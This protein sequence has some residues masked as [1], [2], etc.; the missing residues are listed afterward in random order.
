MAD[1]IRTDEIPPENGV[2]YTE[3]EE[4]S[5]DPEIA[6][7]IGGV[8]GAITGLVAGASAGPVGAAIGAVVGG[9]AGSLASQA[10]VAAI[11]N[12]TD[13]HTH[14]FDAVDG[15]DVLEDGR[16]ANAGTPVLNTGG[17]ID[18]QDRSQFAYADSPGPR[19][20]V[21]GIQTGGHDRD[22]SPDT[23]GIEEKA[24]DLV[25]GDKI[26]DKTGKPVD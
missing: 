14:G 3:E 7:N 25:T 11:D 13:N 10:A 22:G 15:E 1:E 8:G 18:A 2:Q 17:P 21:P 20:G 12:A 5:N 16:Y 9:V 19:N 24:A 6:R 26:D 4:V 23:R